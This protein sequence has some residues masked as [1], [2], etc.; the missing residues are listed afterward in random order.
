VPF[1]RG[2]AARLTAWCSRSCCAGGLGPLG[3][4]G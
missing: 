2:S 1:R 3:Q 4:F